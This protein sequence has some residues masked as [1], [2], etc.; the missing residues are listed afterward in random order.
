M[1]L[2]YCNVETA[3]KASTISD[4]IPVINSDSS[5]SQIGSPKLDQFYSSA[6]GGVVPSAPKP[7]VH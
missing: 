5:D 6:S 4:T 1:I 2:D 3:M 7:R